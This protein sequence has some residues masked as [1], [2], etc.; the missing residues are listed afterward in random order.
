[1]LFKF[2]STQLTLFEWS[3]LRMLLLFEWIKSTTSTWLLTIYLGLWSVLYVLVWWLEYWAFWV[4]YF[5]LRDECVFRKWL[6]V[7]ICR[8]YCIPQNWNPSLTLTILS[9]VLLTSEHL[10]E[11]ILFRWIK[12]SILWLFDL[13]SLWNFTIWLCKYH[14]QKVRPV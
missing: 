12:L 5:K 9:R 4:A 1:M 6:E 8:C 7:K 2:K 13:I 14:N 3:V 11:I 10:L